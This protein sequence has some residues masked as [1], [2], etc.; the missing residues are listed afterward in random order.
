MARMEADVDNSMKS[1]NGDDAGVC[2]WKT[3]SVTRQYNFLHADA[4]FMAYAT[5]VV[6]SMKLKGNY[7]GVF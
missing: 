4:Y 2:V 5:S 7:Y 3:R 1:L 6:T